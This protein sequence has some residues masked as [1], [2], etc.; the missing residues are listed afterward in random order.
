MTPGRRLAPPIE[1]R[2]RDR[3]NNRRRFHRT[4]PSDIPTA[5]G[6]SGPMP[7]DMVSRVAKWAPG[8]QIKVVAHINFTADTG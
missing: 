1:H 7:A 6:S 5:P 2:N 8:D 3:R 4:T